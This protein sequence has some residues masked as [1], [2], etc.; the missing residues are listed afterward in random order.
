LAIDP[1]VVQHPEVHTWVSY[2]GWMD[3]LLQQ[4]LHQAKHRMKKAGGSETF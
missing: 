4:H 1:S 2:R 3:Q